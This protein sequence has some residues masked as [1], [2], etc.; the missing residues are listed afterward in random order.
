M[1]EFHRCRPSVARRAARRG[2]RLL[3]EAGDREGAGRVVERGAD[4]DVAVAGLRRGRAHAEGDDTAGARRLARRWR[5]C[6]CSAAVSAITWS[7]ASSHS[8]ASGSSSATSTRGGGDG[9]RAVAADRLQQDARRGDA[10]GAQLL[11]DQEAVLLVAHDDRRG[12]A[13]AAGAQRGLLQ[14]RVVGDQRPELLGEALARDRPEP[15][16]GAT[17]EDDGD[18]G[19]WCSCG[20]SLPHA[21]PR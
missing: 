14:Q 21:E 4:G 15:G 11:G 18:D 5:G 8:T 13:V 3:D 17:G 2:V 16:A 12:E 19:G 6:A 20:W 10:G 1:P 7:A 9:G